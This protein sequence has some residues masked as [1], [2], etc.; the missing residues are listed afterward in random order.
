[1]QL[2]NQVL[3]TTGICISWNDQGRSA[4]GG[5]KCFCHSE[6]A[7]SLLEKVALRFQ[8]GRLASIGILGQCY[9]GTRTGSLASSQSVHGN[10]T[11]YFRKPAGPC[12]SHLTWLLAVKGCPWTSCQGS[13]AR[14]QCYQWA[15]LQKWQGWLVWRPNN[16][17]RYVVFS[18]RAR[19]DS[20]CL[21]CVRTAGVVHFWPILLQMNFYCRYERQL[22]KNTF[23]FLLSGV[24]AFSCSQVHHVS[25]W[26]VQVSRKEPIINEGERGTCSQF[27]CVSPLCFTIWVPWQCRSRCH[28][29][30]S[31]MSIFLF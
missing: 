6:C 22:V 15:L 25:L 19:A 2:S 23:E 17:F 16:A 14:K 18:S 21:T 8:G 28:F 5:R 24:P 10:K 3:E 31:T 11:D 27:A 13:G 20:H 7:R 9:S 12:C 1:M 26:L 4:T 30:T 29:C